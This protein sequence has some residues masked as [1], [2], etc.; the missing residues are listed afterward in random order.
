MTIWEYL[1]RAS[2]RRAARPFDARL[3]A[4]VIGVA[5]VVGF[6]GAMIALFVI[7]VK[8]AN[9]ELLSYMLG[10]LSGFL[11]GVV[12]Y[13]YA[14]TAAQ[15]QGS[16]SLSKMTDAVR[17]IARSVPNADTDDAAS[18]AADRVADA[19]VDTADQIRGG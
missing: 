10:Q 5:I 18:K 11:G 12:A 6:L 13:H 19:A 8:T 14:S 1:D 16:N 17:E 3:F 15:Q 7:P 4:N 9:K 2:A